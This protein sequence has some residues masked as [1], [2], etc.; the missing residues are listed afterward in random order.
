MVLTSDKCFPY[1]AS[2]DLIYYGAFASHDLQASLNLASDQD[3]LQDKMEIYKQQVD[4][5]SKKLRNLQTQNETLE[6]R[7]RLLEKVV[8]LKD[9]KGPPI[10]EASPVRISLPSPS[11]CTLYFDIS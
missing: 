11:L 8:Q 10:E 2:S 7:N 1:F 6:E 4:E 5:L 9:K 3:I